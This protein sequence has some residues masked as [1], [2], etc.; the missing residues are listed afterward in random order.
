MIQPWWWTAGL[1]L[2]VTVLGLLPLLPAVRE[3]RR[4]RNSALHIPPDDD[5]G[6]GFFA[7]RV[8]V[9]IREDLG[10]PLDF[11]APLPAG[12]RAAPTGAL[13]GIHGLA[14][15]P[16]ET[17][18]GRN[19][20]IASGGRYFGDVVALERFELGEDALV[21]AAL[22]TDG[23]AMLGDGASVLRWV[24]AHEIRAGSRCRLLGRATARTTIVL[25]PG[26]EFRRLA[27]DT[28]RFGAS[29]PMAIRLPT[30]PGDLM[31]IA[32]DR[33]LERPD[34]QGRWVCHG[35]LRIPS[36]LRFDGN[37]IVEGDLWIGA[38]C[39]ITGSIK[40]RGDVHVGSSVRVSGSLFAGHHAALDA[41]VS[42]AGVLS[43][44]RGLRCGD[45]ISVGLPGAPASMLAPV[46]VVGNGGCVHGSVWAARAGTVVA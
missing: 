38:G 40:A 8:R 17:L 24:D 23:F 34:E 15:E 16:A 33:L 7:D 37:I 31:T 26:G 13:A 29:R 19:V 35:T 22:V 41:D 5:A 1:G 4:G 18:V 45:G 46:I 36:G 21:R 27:A 39:E 6:A 44:E 12:Y 43:A 10:E 3:W 25:G 20:S 9:R 11:D 32:G 14:A 28:I 42:I 2:A 30:E